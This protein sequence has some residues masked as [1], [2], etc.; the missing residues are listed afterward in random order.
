MRTHNIPSYH[1]KIKVILIMLPDLALLS[2]LI[3]SNYSCL[4][5]I[6]MVPKL[7]E[8][9]K[10]YC[11]IYHRSPMKTEKSQ[12][13][14]KRILPVNKFPA[15]SLDHRVGISQSASEADI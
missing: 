13:E 12:P 1:R 6:L 15:L 14:G 3:G 7:F 11:R 10:F 2:T 9:L 8:P 5:L 4:E